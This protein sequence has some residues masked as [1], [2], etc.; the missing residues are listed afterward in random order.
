[1]IVSSRQKIKQEDET[2][3]RALGYLV[4]MIRQSLSEQLIFELRP[5]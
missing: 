2:L 5:G 3:T 4:G 1:M